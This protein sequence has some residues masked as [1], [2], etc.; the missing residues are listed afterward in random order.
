MQHKTHSVVSASKG[1]QHLSGELQSAS[2]LDF[3]IDGVS[4]CAQGLYSVSLTSCPAGVPRDCILCDSPP[5]HLP[6][7]QDMIHI[8]DTKMARRYG[9]FFIRQIHKLEEVHCVTVIEK[10]DHSAQIHF[11]RTGLKRC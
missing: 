1:T 11:L 4:G 6:P 5:A 7:I 3:Y 8:A 9:D 10:I 2:D